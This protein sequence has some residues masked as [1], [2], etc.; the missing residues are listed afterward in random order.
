MHNTGMDNK[1]PSMIPS[2]NQIV[3]LLRDNDRALYRAL[4]V[5]NQRQTADERA[6]ETTRYTNGRG[7]NAAHAKRG[8]S[9]A[10]FFL[11]A[12]FLTPKQKAWW[13]APEAK[14]GEMRIAIY[15]GQLQD[16]AR[17]KAE[18]LAAQV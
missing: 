1:E 14:G 18:R 2:K 8:T 16:A 11:R 4:V 10:N 12:G 13:R 9:M 17:E 3:E 15:A 6:S 7:F 5:L